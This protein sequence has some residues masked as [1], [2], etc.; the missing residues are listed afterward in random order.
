[1]TK[2]FIQLI[3]RYLFRQVALAWMCLILASLQSTAIALF[4]EKDLA[5]WKLN[6]HLEIASCKYGGMQFCFSS[7]CFHIALL[8]IL[9]LTLL[10]LLQGTGLAVSC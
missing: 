3:Y 9:D 1:M 4:A 5:A 8:V 6:K 7:D 2:F 10:F